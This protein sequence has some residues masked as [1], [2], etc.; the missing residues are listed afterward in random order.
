MTLFGVSAGA[1]SV[2]FHLLSDMSEGL[3]EKAISQSGTA[4]VTISDGS[5]GDWTLR[6]ANAMG[7]DGVGGEKEIYDFLKSADAAEIV[8][9][10][11]AIITDDEKKRRIS[12]AFAPCVEPYTSEQNFFTKTP[13]ELIKNAWGNKVPLIIGATSEEGLLYYFDVKGDPVAALSDNSFANLLPAELNLT[14]DSAESKRMVRQMKKFYYGQESTLAPNEEN[15][16]RF[17]DILSDKQFLY[18]IH[19]AIKYRTKD[20]QSAA[21]YFYRFNF[22]SDFNAL[23]KMFGFSEIKGNSGESLLLR[24]CF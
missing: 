17:L 11:S 13:A 20:V 9:H 23:R 7:W 16:M 3:F 21:T 10:Q 5:K 12:T 15:V 18:G 6:L 24:I 4:F 8:K 2:H 22:Q 14:N 19:L 1:V